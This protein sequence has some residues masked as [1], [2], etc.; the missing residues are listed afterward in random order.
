MHRWAT[1][2]QLG[3]GLHGDPLIGP[4]IRDELV[5]NM[6]FNL[7]PRVT[8]FDQPDI[9]G[10]ILEDTVQITSKGHKVLT[11]FEYDEKLLN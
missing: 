7:E 3:Y 4:E 9:G 10:V 6:I 11:K 5:P 8:L 1:G 2:H